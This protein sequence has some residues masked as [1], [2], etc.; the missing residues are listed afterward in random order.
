MRAALGLAV[1][2]ALVLATA[3]GAEEIPRPACVALDGVDSLLQSGAVVL[4]GEVHG[5][6]EAPAVVSDV[7]C[8]A[9]RQDLAVTLALEIPREEA[10]RV[11]AWLT[12]AGAAADREALLAG[13]FWHST[14]Q[15]G[16]R[17]E[18][19]LQLLEDARRFAAAGR[20]VTVRLLDQQGLGGVAREQAM[21]DALVAA[22]MEDEN[23]LVIALVGNLHARLAR[24]GPIS[25]P[26]AV[27]ASARLAERQVLALVL[28]SAGGEA[29]T[30]RS[31][32]SGC[33]PG[34][35]RADDEA[36]GRYVRVTDKLE[37]G[38]HGVI[39]VGR[40]HASPPAKNPH[41]DPLPPLHTLTSGEG[42]SALSRPPIG[43]TRR[44]GGGAPLPGGTGAGGRGAGGEGSR[45]AAEPSLKRPVAVTRSRSE[46]HA[47]G[48]WPQ[49]MG[50]GGD[51]G[52][53]LGLLPLGAR[54]GLTIDWRQPLGRGY[55]S[56]TV[57]RGRALTMEADKAGLWLVALDVVD[58]GEIWRVP[59]VEAETEQRERIENPLSTP[60]TDGERVFAIGAEG[61][62]FAVTVED[63]RLLWTR[64]LAE[65]FGASPPS[66]GMS[67]SPLV[68]HGRLW[69]LVGGDEGKNLVSFDSQTGEILH[70]LDHAEVGSYATPVDGVLGGERQIIV[71]A[72][73]RIYAV[74]PADGELL[75]SY[76]GLPF[77]D[78]DPL[79]LSDQRV[80][81]TF[82][83]F[84]ALLQ[85]SRDDDRWQVDE[86]WRSQHLDSS[87]SPAVHHQGAVFGL[88]A[89]YLTCLDAGSG[90]VAWQVPYGSG[91]LIRVDDH[92]VVFRVLPGKLELV[93]AMPD[94]HSVAASATV[95]PGGASSTTPPSFGA[96]RVFLRSAEEIVAVRLDPSAR[97]IPEDESLFREPFSD[98]YQ[99]EGER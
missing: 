6:V 99:G 85:I 27:R 13:S 69:V 58:G 83:E 64:D 59:L 1:S 57:S 55:S 20:P 61:R 16:R 90:E 33:G 93:E 24:G 38:Y 76:D 97:P 47:D 70:S 9:L 48:E 95:F 39:H 14:Y 56:I 22:V 41:P 73:D 19:M 92:L 25:D 34:S 96:G 4:L 17:S 7:V 12:S 43:G 8:H 80:F 50:P 21:A 63:G 44:T 79:L 67:T 98:R 11:D 40:I 15:D 88:D 2:V 28:S 81:F 72:G 54:V 62:L 65:D 75:W 36:T 77:P 49:W 94:R 45:V 35:L 71:P 74:R 82:Q 37:R 78:R 5:T 52:V 60:S 51:G 53:D 68:D 46:P 29:W 84:A 23:H 18:A 26:M 91:S 66:Y 30:C 32:E 89:G 10:S 31:G 3:S 87:Y 86:L 42:T